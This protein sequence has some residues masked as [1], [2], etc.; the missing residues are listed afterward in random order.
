MKGNP[1]ENTKH[2]FQEDWVYGFQWRELRT[3]DVEFNQVRN[4]HLWGRF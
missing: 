2:L 3:G 1:E 4:L